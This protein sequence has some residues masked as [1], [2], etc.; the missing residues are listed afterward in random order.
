MF[1]NE[2][3]YLCKSQSRHLEEEAQERELGGCTMELSRCPAQIFHPSQSYSVLI[4]FSKPW[5][6]YWF[7]LPHCTIK[8]SPQELS[9]AWSPCELSFPPFLQPSHVLARHTWSH[10]PFL[11]L[12]LL[13]WGQ[14]HGPAT[15]TQTGRVDRQ[16]VGTSSSPGWMEHWIHWEG[17]PAHD[18]GV[19][20]ILRSLPTQAVLLL[21]GPPCPEE[22]F[23]PNPFSISDRGIEC[24][25]NST[26]AIGKKMLR[27]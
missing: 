12:Q 6:R 18:R 1:T 5:S 14:G 7:W 16:D 19:G 24:R 26:L 17:V 20:W 10:K 22:Q 3:Q 15:G 9:L 8:F 21:Y 13:Q 23:S 11:P 4:W 2:L 27:N 25:N